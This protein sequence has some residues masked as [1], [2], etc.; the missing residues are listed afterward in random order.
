M[1]TTQLVNEVNA[2]PGLQGSDGIMC[3]DYSVDAFGSPSFHLYARSP[4]LL[5]ANVKVTL[6]A[7]SD[8][9]ISPGGTSTLNQNLS[10]LQPRNHLYLTTGLTTLAANAPLDTTSLPGG[11]HEF[12][13][14]AYEGSSIA[15]Q[16]RSTL[17]IRIQNNS[18]TATLTSSDLG[19]T[20]SV[21]GTYH[22]Q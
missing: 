6:S 3:A 17:P 9:S 15:T 4:G 10:D 11:Y 20:N 13:A 18:L 19:D 7:S 1:M 5:A 22:I 2:E 14:V 21:L 12:T 8:I 16:T